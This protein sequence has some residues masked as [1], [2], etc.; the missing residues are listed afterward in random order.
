MFFVFPFLSLFWKLALAILFSGLFFSLCFSFQV[1]SLFCLSVLV[2]DE[3]LLALFKPIEDELM[4]TE[5]S[6]DL[7]LAF[8][9]FCMDQLIIFIRYTLFSGPDFLK[10][11]SSLLL[12]L[13]V[14]LKDVGSFVTVTEHVYSEALAQIKRGDF[15]DR[16]EEDI[17]SVSL[18][19]KSLLD[20][21]LRQ[22]L[23]PFTSSLYP[24]VVHA[25][26]VILCQ[27]LTQLQFHFLVDTIAEKLPT[28][29]Q[30]TGKLDKAI[31][32]FESLVAGP[33]S[34]AGT[35]TV[36]LP[37]IA[38][39]STAA[40][41]TASG[42]SS[43]SSASLSPLSLPSTSSSSL[44]QLSFYSSRGPTATTVEEDGGA[45]RDEDE[46]LSEKE[47]DCRTASA[48]RAFVGSEDDEAVDDVAA[49]CAVCG[50]RDNIFICT[51]CMKTFY[52][53]VEHQKQH[54]PTHKGQCKKAS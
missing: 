39:S 25:A 38:S 40:Q 41:S 23:L 31:Q 1:C 4:K 30:Q 8:G 24:F 20:P 17:F 10:V 53:S 21:S 28:V 22:Q 9:R 49:A 12:S 37:S 15:P 26:E 18:V 36:T 19:T 43:I 42:S 44:S 16:F 35:T 45:D 52:C 32:I 3:S 46:D 33:A 5:E 51:R 34:V 2:V 14:F 6:S 29:V 50:L 13:K 48:V 11:R 27:L 54:W 7:D 47:Q